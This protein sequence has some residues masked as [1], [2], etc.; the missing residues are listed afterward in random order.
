M[1]DNDAAAQR[2]I[3]PSGVQPHWPPFAPH[4]PPAL[5]IANAFHNQ[6]ILT[7]SLGGKAPEAISFI[8]FSALMR[9]GNLDGSIHV[10]EIDG[11]VKIAP[12]A[13]MHAYIF[14]AVNSSDHS[15]PKK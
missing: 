12:F 11:T 10:G 7:V 2:R 5:P 6:D 4:P 9:D 15:S 1:S 3:W 13:L 8:H 14:G